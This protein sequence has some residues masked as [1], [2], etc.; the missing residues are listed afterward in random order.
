MAESKDKKLNASVVIPTFNGE[1]Y[2]RDLLKQV[3]AQKVPF[4]FEVI[5]IDSGSKDKT[6]DIISEF[7]EVKLKNIPNSEFGH[8]KTRNMAAEMAEGEFIIYLSQDAVPASERWLEFM[9]EPF[10]LSE[11]VVCVFGKQVPRP[12]CDITTKREVNGVFNSLGPEH[13]VMI[14]LK[15]SLVSNK[16]RETFLTFFSDVNS[17]VRKEFITNTIPYRDVRYSEDQLLGSDIL[18]AGYFKAYS[19]L[20][21]VWHSNEYK[22]SEYFYRKHDE[23]MGMY[24]VLGVVPSSKVL[25]RIKWCVVNTLRD[26]KATIKDGDYPLRQKVLNVFESPIRNLLRQYAEHLVSNEKHRKKVGHS[27]SLEAKRKNG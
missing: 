4:S 19:P 23:Y 1:L 5:V 7:P 11:K 16:E 9:I 8:G 17:A 25:A 10:L 3:F 21:W 26:F 18:K 22:L 12:F 13:S 2:L 20:G 27:K 24:D 6:L 14:N 15:N